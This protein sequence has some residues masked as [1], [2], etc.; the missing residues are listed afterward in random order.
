[1][2]RK[3]APA[4]ILVFVAAL[5]VIVVLPAFAYNPDFWTAKTPPPIPL[6]PKSGQAAVFDGKIYVL[7]DSD[8]FEMYDPNNNTWIQ[9]APL[10]VQQDALAVCGDKIYA[11]G[12][13]NVF[14]AYDPA[15]DSWTAKAAMPLGLADCQ[16]N[17]VD[18][19]IYVMGGIFALSV[20]AETLDSNFAYDPQH[21]LWSILAPIPVAVGRFASAVVD[22]K[23][24]LMGGYHTN[25]WQNIWQNVPPVAATNAVQIFDPEMNSWSQ[26]TPMPSNMVYLAGCATTGLG[27]AKRIYVVGG[28]SPGTELSGV[29]LTQIYDPQTGNWSMGAPLPNGDYGLSLVN[30]DDRLYALGGTSGTLNIMYTPEGWH[31]PSSSPSPS[32]S[33]TEQPAVDYWNGKA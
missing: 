25:G 13:S 28:S 32:P 12:A 23:I 2:N 30:V 1:M 19:K 29:N 5:S 31:V 18:G 7:C 33:P 4:L 15:N 8:Q 11:M 10:P 24:Y 14:L 9:K 17:V 16:A 27:A 3:L 26:G 21:D 22:G 6:V 20:G